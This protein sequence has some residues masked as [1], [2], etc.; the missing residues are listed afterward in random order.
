M[1]KFGVAAIAAIAFITAAFGGA[2]PAPDVNAARAFIAK[3]YSHYPAKKG[4]SFAPTDKNAPDVFD[5]GMVALFREDTRLAKGEVGFVDADPICMCQD[6]SGLKSKIVSVAMNGPNAATA[7]VDLQY[8]DSGN[9]PNLLTL[10]L[11]V[12][13]GEWRVYDLSMGDIKSYRADLTKANKEA[14]AGHY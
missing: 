7:V 11:V 13:K 10:H 6:D 5:P 9:K 14:A 2:A 3:L 12:V 8:P 4:S 1:R